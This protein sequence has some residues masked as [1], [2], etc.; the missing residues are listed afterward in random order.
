MKVRA[1]NLFIRKSSY[2]YVLPIIVRGRKMTTQVEKLPKQKNKNKNPNNKLRQFNNKKSYVTE[3]P[4]KH[5][6]KEKKSNQ[7]GLE[8]WLSG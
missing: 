1:V 4:L 5:E 2:Q 6:G 8:R 3:K 7:R